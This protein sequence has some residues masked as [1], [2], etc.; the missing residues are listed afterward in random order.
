MKTVPLISVAS[1]NACQNRCLH[2][3]HQGMRDEDPAY[4]MPL[5]D[6]TALIERF[7]S[8]GCR[9]QSISLCGPG[10]PLI[11]KH[12]NEAVRLIAR[13]GIADRIE[14]TTNGLALCIIE[15]DVWQMLN[16]L[17]ISGYGTI[18]KTK[19]NAEHSVVR[20]RP[21]FWYVDKS[22]I[23]ATTF[24]QCGCP[25][26]TYYKGHI[27]PYCGPVLFDACL[28]SGKKHTDFSVPLNQFDPDRMPDMPHL[29]YL[30]CAWCWG[31]PV[32]PKIN[33]TWNKE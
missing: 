31:N 14:A 28:L 17:F 7:K 6:V 21:Q 19:Y 22:K 2:C 11:W 24:T 23:P 15:E 33:F 18:D 25:G 13:S 20:P 16:P 27:Y 32:V 12:F 4:Q 9:T 26:M 29:K 3:A 8:L 1:C 5:E 10:E 30:P